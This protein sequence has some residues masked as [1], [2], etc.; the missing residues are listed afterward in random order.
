MSTFMSTGPTQP[1]PPPVAIDAFDA[2]STSSP[3]DPQPAD[4]FA[5]CD[6]LTATAPQST[7][8]ENGASIWNEGLT[9]GILDLSLKSP[10]RSSGMSGAPM[11]Q[12]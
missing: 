6:G 2:F 1:A 5:F 11:R 4:P 12:R 7:N 10:D 3:R 8:G 9:K